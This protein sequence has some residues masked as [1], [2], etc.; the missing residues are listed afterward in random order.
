MGALLALRPVDAEK[1]IEP[2]IS[3]LSDLV[4]ATGLKE[5]GTHLLTFFD[6][7]I[8]ADH[9]AVYQFQNYEFAEITSAGDVTSHSIP[10]SCLGTYEV[11]RRFRQLSSSDTRVE[12]YRPTDSHE[13]SLSSPIQ[14]QGLMVLG[15][16]LDSLFCIRILRLSQRNE[17]SQA[18]INRL[19]GLAELIISL[20]A[21]HQDLTHLKPNEFSAL[22]SLETIE[23]RIVNSK[24][25][26]RRETE[27]CSRIIFGCSSNEIASELGIGKESVMTYR[28]RAYQRLEICSQRELLFWYLEQPPGNPPCPGF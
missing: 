27:V 18:A 1:V 5:F 19:R 15:G 26:S 2:W 6:R 24:K 7:H 20:V 11:K 22:T 10:K 16:K 21:R 17:I 25:L 13:A 23:K 4:E 28:K 8:G 3:G 9:C 14:Q 12:F